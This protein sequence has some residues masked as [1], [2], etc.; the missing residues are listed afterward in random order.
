MKLAI[1]QKIPA[2]ESQSI[3]RIINYL[4]NATPCQ[5]ISWRRARL[6][7]K[8]RHSFVIEHIVL[9]APGKLI[10]SV[11]C[12]SRGND[13]RDHEY[14]LPVVVYRRKHALYRGRSYAA[15]YFPSLTNTGSRYAGE[16]GWRMKGKIHHRAARNLRRVSSKF[17]VLSAYTVSLGKMWL[18]KYYSICLVKDANF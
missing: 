9:L 4:S 16:I 13:T 17:I 7:L 2:L 1:D 3:S 8:T 14:L 15:N 11:D 5:K 10:P 6:Y 18:M 12:K